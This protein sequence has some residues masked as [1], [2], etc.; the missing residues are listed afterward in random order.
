[1]AKILV[2]DDDPAIRK[3]LVEFLLTKNLQVLEATNGAEAIEMV[4][5]E[6]L[7]LILLDVSMPGMTGIETL[8]KIREFNKE[9]GV[10]MATANEDEATAKEAAEL[11]SYQYVLK[12][13]DL[14]Y[15]ELVVL[16]RLFMA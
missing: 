2:V 13:F 7:D 14:K 8:R 3:L 11:G 16:T 15:L 10:V 12:P 4:K 5:R 1:M 6:K 9:I